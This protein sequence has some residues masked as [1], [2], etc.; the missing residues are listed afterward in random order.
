MC[1][2]VGTHKALLSSWEG[3]VVYNEASPCL[4]DCFMGVERK[5]RLAYYVLPYL[6]RR[7]LFFLNF[8][9]LPNAQEFQYFAVLGTSCN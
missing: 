1:A 2:G 9:L 5:R 6:F 4:R 8:N 7:R 3:K